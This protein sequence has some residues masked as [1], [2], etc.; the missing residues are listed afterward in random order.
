MYK[1]VD[2]WNNA[3]A[4]VVVTPQP[5]S[6]GGVRYPDVRYSGAGRAFHG[7]PFVDLVWTSLERDQYNTIMTQFGLSQT[8]ASNDVT[9][10]IRNN[11]DTFSNYNAVASYALDADRGLA[12][13][14]NLIIRVEL[15][16]A[17]T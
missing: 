15:I 5:A 6:P 3:G 2:G 10:A 9:A 7:F 16:E 12:F 4:M 11:D 8:V 13:W 14:R 17:A 1:V